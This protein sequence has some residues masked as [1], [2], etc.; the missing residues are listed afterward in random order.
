[1]IY[2]T[3]NKEIDE[4]YK[5]FCCDS[6]PADESKIKNQY[7]RF[8]FKVFDNIREQYVYK[9]NMRYLERFDAYAFVAKVNRFKKVF[10]FR[11]F[12]PNKTVSYYFGDEEELTTLKLYHELEGRP[13]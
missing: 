8:N 12:L 13:V 5:E 11:A 7:D 2:Y 1:M 3:S 4:L 9:G 6:L 10:V